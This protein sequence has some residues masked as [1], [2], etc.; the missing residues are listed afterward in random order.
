MVA[1]GGLIGGL[2][3]GKIRGMIRGALHGLA[4]DPARLLQTAHHM[5]TGCPDRVLQ[6]HRLRNRRGAVHHAAHRLPRKAGGSR[7][8]RH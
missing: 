4:H 8:G 3:R 5:L 7:G 6:A 1:R 2:A